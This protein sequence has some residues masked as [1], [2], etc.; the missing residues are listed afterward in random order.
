MAVTARQL[1]HEYIDRLSEDDA[2]ATAA[3]LLEV[4]KRTLRP[5]ERAL[6]ERGLAEADAGQLIPLEEVEA[7]FG[8]R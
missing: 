5:G 1:L 7:E 6:I 2:I 4:D 3:I 8:V